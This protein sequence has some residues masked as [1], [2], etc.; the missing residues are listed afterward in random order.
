ML[1]RTA[2]HA[3]LLTLLDE[4]LPPAFSG[5]FRESALDE[6]RIMPLDAT[7]TESAY[8]VEAQLPGFSR[9]EIR[10]D[11]DGPTV[12][13]SAERKKSSESK[14]ESART[15]RREISR[16]QVSRSMTFPADIDSE[17]ARAK[18]ENGHLLLDL[19]KKARSRGTSLQIS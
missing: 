1:A 16:T 4:V 5:A 14:D 2:P 10:V 8:R 6:P 7:E 11:I 19:P 18:L 9:E 13:I 3:A 17:N 12:T 15:L